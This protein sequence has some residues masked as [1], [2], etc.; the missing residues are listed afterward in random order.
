MRML[1]REL[2][3]ASQKEDGDYAKVGESFMMQNFM[4]YAINYID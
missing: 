2:W 4:N 1:L 3:I